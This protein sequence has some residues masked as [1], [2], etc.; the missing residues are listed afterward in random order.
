MKRR[1]KLL[2]FPVL[3]LVLICCG[4]NQPDPYQYSLPELTDDGWSVGDADEAGLR[5]DFLSDMM[6]YIRGRD[7]PA[8][9]RE[10][11]SFY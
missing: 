4:K 2:L 11:L 1:G 6:D 7:G 5:T 3:L 9:F 8:R 10:Q